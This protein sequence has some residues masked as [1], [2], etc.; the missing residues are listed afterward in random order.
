MVEVLYQCFI[1]EDHNAV[2]LIEQQL[3]QRLLL[4]LFHCDPNAAH[5]PHPQ[6]Q[7]QRKLVQDRV[8]VPLHIKAPS[9]IPLHHQWELI[10]HEDHVVGM[11]KL[12]GNL[13]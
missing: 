5:P 9:L 8:V 10:R 1:Q 6:R 11:L 7:I 2:I 13:R 12:R 4:L 3:R